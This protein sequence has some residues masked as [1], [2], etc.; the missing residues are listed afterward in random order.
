MARARNTRFCVWRSPNILIASILD[1]QLKIE[2]GLFSGNILPD[3]SSYYEAMNQQSTI[4][5]KGAENNVPKGKNVLFMKE[6]LIFCYKHQV[7]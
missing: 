3:S 1:P 5:A 7:Y 2:N 4:I 6:Y